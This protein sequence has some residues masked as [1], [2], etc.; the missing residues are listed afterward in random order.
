MPFRP[1]KFALMGAILAMSQAA[2][3]DEAEV[4]KAVLSLI[5][6]ATIDSIN[7]APLAG[8]SEVVVGG[9]VVYVTNDGKHLVQ[10]PLYDVSNKLDLTEST[11]RG[12]RSKEMASQKP[13]DRIVFKAKGGIPKYKVAV[14]TD[15]DCGYCRRM[16]AQVPEYAELGIEIDYLMFPRAG[17]PSDSSRKAIS[18]WCAKDNLQ[19]M[20]DAKNGK[21]PASMTCANPIEAQFKLGQ[22][23]G[24]TGTPSMVLEDGTLVPGYLPP[25]DLLARLDQLKAAK[26]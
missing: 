13:A 16:H 8:F 12:I 9:H 7:P 2:S 23:V 20:T 18:V 25:Q 15:I 19:A 3:A 10:G 26:K 22:R 21:D 5:P 17:V 1:F 4:R 24:V 6:S 14:F 11:M